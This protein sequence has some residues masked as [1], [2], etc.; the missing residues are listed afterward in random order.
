MSGAAFRLGTRRPE[1]YR[2]A[3]ENAL[4][5]MSALTTARC[6]NGVGS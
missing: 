6:G 5:R 4:P 1:V 2:V 3:T